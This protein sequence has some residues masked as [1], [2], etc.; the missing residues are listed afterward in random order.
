[1]AGHSKFANIRHRKNAQDAK[2]GKLFTKLIREITVAARLGDPDPSSNPR[3]RDAVEKALKANMTRETIGRAIK[4]GN[5][6]GDAKNIEEITY[7]GYGPG[8]VAILVKCLTDNRNRSVADVRYA[9]NKYGGNWG[10]SGSVAY[11]FKQCGVLY[12]GA[13]THNSDALVEQVLEQEWDVEDILQ[14]ED[15]SVE[16]FTDPGQVFRVKTQL[17]DAGFPPEEAE[18]T[19]RA[20][21]T[22]VINETALYE[23]LMRLIDY[24]EDLEDVQHVYTNADIVIQGH[25]Q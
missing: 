16:I 25:L 15:G 6:E 2:R 14:N 3:L 17:S 19:L 22:V 23:S 20:S 5:G 12:Y 21:N 24:L 7:E 10:N 1:M 13:D 4:R 9:F 18:V 11:L 8:G